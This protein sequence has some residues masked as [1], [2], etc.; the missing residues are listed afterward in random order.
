MDRCEA[1]PD[2]EKNEYVNTHI[3]VLL[4]SVSFTHDDFFSYLIFHFM[5]IKNAGS[6]SGLDLC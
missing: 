5:P 1:G 4:K 6:G 2:F 3:H